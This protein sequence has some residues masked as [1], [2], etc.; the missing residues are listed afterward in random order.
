V[1]GIFLRANFWWDGDVMDWGFFV[2]RKTRPKEPVPS[3]RWIVKSVIL[4]EDIDEEKE[5][6]MELWRRWE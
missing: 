1:R 2:Q 5:D 3:C 6:K 4:E